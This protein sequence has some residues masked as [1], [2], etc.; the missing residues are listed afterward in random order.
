MDVDGR[1]DKQSVVALMESVAPMTAVI[2]RG[3]N[4]AKDFMKQQC[5]LHCAKVFSCSVHTV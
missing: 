2:I 4:K 5:L 1:A 3:S